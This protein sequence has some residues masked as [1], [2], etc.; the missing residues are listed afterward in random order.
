SGQVVRRRELIVPP[1]WARQNGTI[2]IT[3]S[4]NDLR[5]AGG[6]VSA[7][8]AAM[9]RYHMRQNQRQ[10]VLVAID[11]LPAVGLRNIADYLSTCGGYGV[12]LLLYVQSVAQLQ[13]LYGKDGTRAILSNCDHQLWYPAAEMETARFMSELYGTMLKASPMQ[14]ASRSARQQR[15]KEGKVQTQMTNNQGA[16]WSWREGAALSP[17]EM[18]ALP[19]GQVLATMLAGRRYVF[20]GR[21]LN[22][23][24]LFDQFPAPNG[25]RLPR[26]IYRPRRYTDWRALSAP[27]LRDTGGKK[28]VSRKK[29]PQTQPEEKS[30]TQPKAAEKR[31]TDAFAKPTEAGNGVEKAAKPDSRQPSGRTKLM[32]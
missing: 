22:S 15:D 7:T 24:H 3:Y 25:L 9:L 4:L 8:I 31:K 2:F 11:E 27:P 26:P 13:S 5:A 16:S 28:Q 23:I 12:T 17:N 21:R 18:M 20:L 29:P 19:Q 32:G 6:V 10:K 30:E 1:D 14:S